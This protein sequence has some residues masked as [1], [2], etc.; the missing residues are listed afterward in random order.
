[1][2]DMTKQALTSYHPYIAN[3][4][5]YVQRTIKLSASTAVSVP[6]PDN[7]IAIRFS[8]SDLTKEFYARL[9]ATPTISD[10]AVTD[11]TSGEANPQMWTLVGLTGSS[12]TIG[13]IS[14]QAD[15]KITISCYTGITR[16]S[17]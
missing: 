9:N 12:N 11:G 3:A 16:G 4:P 7:T 6:I 2:A 8:R 15:H 10:A 13:I 17:V 1:M 5:T 14:E